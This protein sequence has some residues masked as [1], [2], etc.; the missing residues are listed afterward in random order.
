[1]VTP[2]TGKA[3][4]GFHTHV[5]RRLTGQMTG[6][7]PDGRWRYTSEEAAREEVGFLTMEEYIRRQKNTAAQYIDTRSLLDL[8]EGSER[9]LGARLGMRWWEK[10]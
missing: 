2:C 10:V 8:C 9:D 4:G 6:R 1:M 7:T 3:L 5:E